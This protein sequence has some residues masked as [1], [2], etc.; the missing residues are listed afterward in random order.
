M[1]IRD[2]PGRRDH[3]LAG[4]GVQPGGGVGP[5]GGDLKGGG[6][7]RGGHHDARARLQHAHRRARPQ[8]VRPHAAI[9]PLL[10]PFFL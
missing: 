4:G 8:G 6:D 9:R 7:A 3:D 10:S 2:S 5:R 1:C